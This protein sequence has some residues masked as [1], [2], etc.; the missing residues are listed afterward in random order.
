MV[1]NQKNHCNCMDNDI[2]AF[3]SVPKD[4]TFTTPL[5]VS[6]SSSSSSTTS[7]NLVSPSLT[8]DDGYS[9]N[10]VAPSSSSSST[11]T[12]TSGRA[13]PNILLDISSSAVPVNVP[14]PPPQA[15]LPGGELCVHVGSVEVSS[16]HLEPLAES[17]FIIILAIPR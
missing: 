6:T 13:S 4:D 10:Y 8:D 12:I 9:S 1:G 16:M 15:S 14:P 2:F 7:A 17:N 5:F 11:S 3:F